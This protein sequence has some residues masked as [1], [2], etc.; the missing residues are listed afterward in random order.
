MRPSAR[1]PLAA[2]A[3]M[4]MALP[5]ARANEVPARAADTVIDPA[6][7]EAIDAHGSARVLVVYAAAESAA[8]G[9]QALDRSGSSVTVRFDSMPVVGATIDGVG[10]DTLARD[11]AVEAVYADEA[12]GAADVTVAS[13][14]AV[15]GGYGRDAA[16]GAG[17]PAEAR[18]DGWWVAIVDSGVDLTHPYL[19]GKGGPG[20]DGLGDVAAC[21]SSGPVSGDG[22]GGCPGG[23]ETATGAAAGVPCV[24][25]WNT[26][27]HGTHVA[28]I[29]A[30][31][32]AVA[33]GFT[34]RDGAAPGAGVYPVQIFSGAADNEAVV[35]T[36]D[37]IA[38]L[39]HIDAQ[40]A[41][42]RF[43]AVNVS[44][45]DFRPHAGYC[46]TAHPLRQVIARLAAGGVPVVA[47]AGNEGESDGVDS[48]ACFPEAVTVSA[49]DM[50]MAT[51]AVA[52]FSNAHP[53]VTDFV[54]GGT[55]VVSSEPGGGYAY[56][57]GTSMATP[58][59]VG[60]IAASR[61]LAPALDGAGVVELLATSARPVSDPRSGAI[62]DRV[63]LASAV[64]AIPGFVPT[65]PWT[66]PTWPGPGTGS[67]AAGFDP[68]PPVRVAD[69]R[70]GTGIARR[71][72][73]DEHATVSIAAVAAGSNPPIAAI[74]A[75]VTATGGSAAGYLTVW[76]C[77]QP[78]PA[79]S[80]VNFT[81]GSTDANAVAVGA[82]A[83]GS[84]CVYASAPVDVIVDLTGV[85]RS[86]GAGYRPVVPLRM[87]DTRTAGA[88]V[89]SA[90]RSIVLPGLPVD[91][92][93]VTVNVTAVDPQ[94]DGYVTIWPCGQPM[95][96]TSN[97]NMVAGR[98]R[99]N[100][101]AVGVGTGGA[102][103]AAA[104]V[105]TDLVVDLQGWF[106]QGSP[107]RFFP[108]VPA[109]VA[110]SRSGAGIDRLAPGATEPVVLGGVPEGASVALNVT[111]TDPAAD[112]FLIVW[113]CGH[114]KPLASNVNYSEG[115]TIPNAV[116]SGVGTGGR[117]CV[118]SYAATDVVIDL[119][120]AW[121]N[122]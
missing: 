2:V 122:P 32:S 15:D 61:Q 83:A 113:P 10:L 18:G 69:S 35:W 26:C 72:A 9:E 104:S 16:G 33:T 109:R 120:G 97:L 92:N 67:G 99:P 7:T 13:A 5:L 11:P 100:L 107:L 1:L 60:A 23:G 85:F 17:A 19:A 118:S 4:A 89:D 52:S 80:S 22:Q 41:H 110:D 111:V 116:V 103:C 81:A 24:W 82:S 50:T 39:E 77:D 49:A 79:A 98:D 94:G 20:N 87:L 29:A 40:R 121:T 102:I 88:P 34:P 112:G 70:V 21:F 68:I 62:Y 53:E 37:L 45:V 90:P 93:A 14:A 105:T 56:R 73:A 25:N 36:A 71:L 48:P 75:N 115:Q 66:P 106:E 114:A 117:V 76:P 38:A 28:G 84:V 42:Y 78:R 58:A 59:V 51:P 65:P 86:D 91:A 6:V 46:A 8:A 54:A 101:V 95:P 108:G 3:V 55:K 74:A 64:A 44:I 31:S 12:L 30:G 57:S 119:T 47:A 96:A 27:G 63:D 43:A